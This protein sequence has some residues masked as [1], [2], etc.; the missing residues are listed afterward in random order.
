MYL[1]IRLDVEF[2]FFAREGA[3]SARIMEI[4]ILYQVG[5]GFEEVG[6]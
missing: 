5:R 6:G 3:D 4:S 1:V 2:D